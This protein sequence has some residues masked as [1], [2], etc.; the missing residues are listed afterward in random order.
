LDVST[1]ALLHALREQR[2]VSNLTVDELQ[3]KLMD[4]PKP[5][6]DESFPYPTI[7]QRATFYVTCLPPHCEQKLQVAQLLLHAYEALCYYHSVRH[8]QTYKE[9]RRLSLQHMMMA[10]QQHHHH[11]ADDDDDATVSKTMK[12]PASTCCWRKLEKERERQAEECASAQVH[13]YKVQK[14]FETQ[15][16]MATRSFRRAS[17]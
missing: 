12:S 13:L 15:Q 3:S 17:V 1:R 14:W 11:D 4:H 9:C 5:D 10:Q 2:G 7:L 6:D 16:R 8:V